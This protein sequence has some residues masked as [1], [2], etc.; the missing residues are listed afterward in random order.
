MRG[1]QGP[2]MSHRAGALAAVT[3]V[4]QLMEGQPRIL[5]WKEGG[6]QAGKGEVEEKNRCRKLR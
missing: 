2:D 3:R 4:G 1:Q 5:S 6:F